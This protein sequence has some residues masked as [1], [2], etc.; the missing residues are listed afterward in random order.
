MVQQFFTKLQIKQTELRSRELRRKATG[1]IPLPGTFGMNLNA[2]MGNGI[3]KIDADQVDTNTGGP[4]GGIQ[5]AINKWII[6]PL[7]KF[8]GFAWPLIARIIPRSFGELW[9]TIVQVGI[10][11]WIFDWNQTDQAIQNRI[12]QNNQQILSAAASALG[13][14][15]G[16]NAVRMTSLAMGKLFKGRANSSGRDR[17]LDIQMPVITGRVSAA[18]A[19]EGN[20]EIRGQ[21]AALLSQI[22]TAQISNTF[23]ATMLHARAEGWLG[24]EKKTKAGVNDSF[25]Q[26]FETF[27][28]TLPQWLQQPFENFTEEFVEAVLEAGYIAAN[29][30]DSAW[31]LARSAA[32][33]A[34]GP[35]RLVVLQPDKD[36]ENNKYVLQGSQEFVIEETER[37]LHEE[38]L[39]RNKDVGILIGGP[40]E[41]TLRK[42]N[43]VRQLKIRW[44]TEA[45]DG[46]PLV[47]A[48]GIPGKWSE[49]NIPMIK[50]GLSWQEVK[51]AADEF[52]KSNPFEKLTCKCFL[53]DKYVGD[54]VVVA[55]SR[56]E[57]EQRAKKLKRLINPE[58]EYRSENFSRGRAASSNRTTSSGVRSAMYYPFDC[59]LTVHRSGAQ[60][61]ETWDRKGRYGLEKPD[62]KWFEDTMKVPLWTSRK[63][64]DFRGFN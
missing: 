3:R 63:P 47:D 15:L 6:N 59:T 58:V 31:I 19:E 44:N 37:I 7:K 27:K 4:L 38:Q 41:D 1:A 8:T 16:W 26:R 56:F 55:D 28:E 48:R 5:N 33:N 42:A 46:P 18:L 22:K 25:A 24:L 57:C 62:T 50:V 39:M 14:A 35:E 2:A 9:S 40:L 64:D 54:L 61:S 13:T 51:A 11:V 23:L 21:L 32:Q 52:T 49:V 36:N 43:L 17:S 34:K 45:K 30:L 53:K 60:D 10:Q 20:E 12:N 29:E